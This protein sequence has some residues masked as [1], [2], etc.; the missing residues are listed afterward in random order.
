MEWGACPLS[1]MPQHPV[2]AGC[3]VAVP[4]RTKLPLGADG[5]GCA[6]S[7]LRQERQGLGWVGR[8]ASYL[9]QKWG[10]GSVCIFTVLPSFL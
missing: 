10:L 9:E 8:E 1:R 6:P 4:V 3:L 7:G 5:V 2:N